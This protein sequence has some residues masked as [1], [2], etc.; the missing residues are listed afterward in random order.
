MP[1][2]AT[3]TLTPA[4]TST[5]RSTAVCHRHSDTTLTPN[6]H[7][8]VTHT[9]PAFRVTPGLRT[10]QGTPT[11]AIRMTPTLHAGR[12]AAVGLEV[13]HLTRSGRSGS[14]LVTHP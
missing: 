8:G 10:P 4:H 11:L 12:V 7:T 13:T 3:P 14:R 6:S 5:P 2:L 1:S 9:T